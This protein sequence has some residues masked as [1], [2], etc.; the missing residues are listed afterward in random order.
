[1][2]AA[3]A[4]LE[5]W[6]TD[7][8]PSESAA[9]TRLLRGPDDATGTPATDADNGSLASLGIPV[10]G[11]G[12]A[13]VPGISYAARL[14]DEDDPAR[15][16]ALSDADRTRIGEDG[17]AVTDANSRGIVRA[18]GRAGGGALAIV[19]ATIGSGVAGGRDFT[20]LAWRR[21]P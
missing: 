16:T 20:V 3:I 11:L 8:F 5:Q 7:G 14:F 17:S 1:V 9:L 12:L 19:E 15:G 4:K 18:I 21:V 10:A 6:Q 13:G 2:A